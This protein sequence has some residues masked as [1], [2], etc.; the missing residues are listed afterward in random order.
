MIKRVVL[1][2]AAACAAAM[3]MRSEVNSTLQGCILGTLGGCSTEPSRGLTNQIRDELNR[4]GYS[5]VTLDP[6]WVHCSGACVDILQAPAASALLDSTRA[7]N[8]YITCECRTTVR[9]K[10]SRG[11]AAMMHRD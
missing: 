4:M 9:C 1:L 10:R 7:K 2:A 5:F 8:D 3:P 6:A 11:G